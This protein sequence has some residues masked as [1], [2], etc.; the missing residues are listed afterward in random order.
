M[1][2]G[3]G[4]DAFLTRKDRRGAGLARVHSR[5]CMPGVH[6]ISAE[7]RPRT[8]IT[9]RLHVASAPQVPRTGASE[10][11][12]SNDDG[13]EDGGEEIPGSMPVKWLFVKMREPRA[14][15]A[16]GLEAGRRRRARRAPGRPGAR[17]VSCRGC[18]LV[19]PWPKPGSLQ[20]DP[21]L[22]QIRAELKAQD[23]TLACLCSPQSKIAKG[24]CAWAPAVSRGC[25]HERVEASHGRL[26]DEI[27]WAWTASA[28][29]RSVAFVRCSHWKGARQADEAKWVRF[30]ELETR[31]TVGVAWPRADAKR[32]WPASSYPIDRLKV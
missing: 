16:L 10:G 25:E 5:G 32:F 27:D 30:G 23:R 28:P 17:V 18:R 22:L 14:P 9:P 26:S 6:R 13:Q 7:S 1:S 21:L 29:S 8:H 11:Q 19:V 31:W 24:Y 12:E 20:E 2:G 15:L 4:D 3:E